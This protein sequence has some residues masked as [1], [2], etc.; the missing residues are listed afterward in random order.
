MQGKRVGAPACDVPLTTFL[1]LNLQLVLFCGVLIIVLIISIVS[2]GVQCAFRSGGFC[3]LGPR[4]EITP[5]ALL[6]ERADEWGNK[7]NH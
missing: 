6:W 7:P 2:F 1:N 3:A 4:R 5:P